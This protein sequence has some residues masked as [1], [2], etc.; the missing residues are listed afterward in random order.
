MTETN[1]DKYERTG[2]NASSG[3]PLRAP[4]YTVPPE[5]FRLPPTRE[6]D[7]YFGLGR[8]YWNSKIL[9]N[10][11]NNFKPEIKSYVIR[12]KG[13]RSGV[14]LIDFESAKAFIFSHVQNAISDGQ[15][16]SAEKSQKG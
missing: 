6:R 11:G 13:S 10:R 5:T 8:S 1:S 12:K 3:Q 9:P 2:V 7:P 15:L 16:R 4:K 14:R